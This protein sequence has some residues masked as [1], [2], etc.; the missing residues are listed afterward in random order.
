MNLLT[1]T[2]LT[3]AAATIIPTTPVE[4]KY[5][6]P[7][8]EVSTESSTRIYPTSESSYVL[9]TV[10]MD[11]KVI[12]EVPEHTSEVIL[13]PNEIQV[14]A[15]VIEAEAG[16]QDL[17]GKCL[18]MDVILNRVDSPNFP[19]D[20]ISVVNQRGQFQVMRNGA[21]NRAAGRV[22]PE[23]YQAVMM[24]CDARGNRG[25]LYFSRGKQRYASNH[26]KYM[27]H[28]FGY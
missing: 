10:D 4:V 19:N 22:S 17:I 11:V 23:S 28:W 13:S 20:L 3:L 6:E 2:M 24:E 21:Y 9:D 16:N 14:A 5:E 15:Q 18:V 7:E 25:V 12:V 27:D 1:H 26:F 8:T